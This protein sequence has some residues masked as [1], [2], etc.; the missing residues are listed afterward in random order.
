[1]KAFWLRWWDRS[2]TLLLWGREQIDQEHQRTEQERQRADQAEGQLVQA[3][4]SLLTQGQVAELVG[5]PVAQVE[6]LAAEA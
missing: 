3:A 2:E 1:M 4:R 5:L 6:G